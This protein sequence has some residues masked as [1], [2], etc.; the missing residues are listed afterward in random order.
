MEITIN[1]KVGNEVHTFRV[2]YVK[3]D[4]NNEGQ[5]H[6]KKVNSEGH[7]VFNP[8][9]LMGCNAVLNF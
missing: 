3:A 6:A 2:E 7:I 1:G 5:L 8:E 4:P 9:R